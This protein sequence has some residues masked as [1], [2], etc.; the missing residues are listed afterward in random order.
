MLYMHTNNL[1]SGKVLRFTS[2]CHHKR[3]TDLFLIGKVSTKWNGGP[4]T[5]TRHKQTIQGHWMKPGAQLAS[6]RTDHETL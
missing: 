2:L 1:S 4:E 3:K 5:E 6:V